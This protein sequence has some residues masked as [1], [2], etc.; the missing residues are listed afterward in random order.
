MGLVLQF[1]LTSEDTTKNKFAAVFISISRKE[2]LLRANMPSYNNSNNGVS[3]KHKREE[4]AQE[5][6][7]KLHRMVLGKDKNINNEYVENFYVDMAKGYD[8]MSVAAGIDR[9]PTIA[10]IL[11]E[12]FPTNKDRANARVLDLAA[13]TGLVGKDLHKIG[14]TNMDAV[15]FSESMLEE[16]RKK[17]VYT[18]DYCGRLGDN[19]EPI[20]GIP[21]GSYDVV[22]IAGGFAHGHLNIQVL[23][24]AAR[25]LKEGGLFVN[26]MSEKYTK[27]V[28]ELRGLDPLIWKMEEEGI[29]KYVLR[30]I[31][32]SKWPGLFQVCRKLS[33]KFV[34][35]EVGK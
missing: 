25:A 5:N 34:L 15:D 30:L 27:I 19:T 35:F 26:A 3:I 28:P 24:Q 33:T 4:L 14:F 6:V 1:V 29:W 18:K 22:V 21:D 9:N 10:K 13:G 23:R 11:S 31:E 32:E 7:E 8:D 17:N 16:L 12:Y 20:C 2:T